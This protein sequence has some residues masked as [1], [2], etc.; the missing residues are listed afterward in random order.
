VSTEPGELR[1]LLVRHGETD[2]NREQRIQGQLQVPLNAVGLRQAELAAERV[3]QYSFAAAYASDLVRARETAEVL[4]A[5]L[6]G[7]ELQFDEAL[8]EA[9]FGLW[10][11]LTYGEFRAAA[12]EAAA[13]WIEAPE[14]V[15][16]PGGE[17]LVQMRARVVAFAQALLGLHPGQTLLL[18]THGGPIRALVAEVT[19]KRMTELPDPANGSLTL[20]TLTKSGGEL[21]IYNDIEH[22]AKAN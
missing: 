9:N 18:V 12:P 17:S 5:R 20:I 2:W 11:G 8:R 16:A 1:L 7:L 4:L 13:Q 3:A 21:L 15:E 22:L 10:E 14:E 19:G 6:P